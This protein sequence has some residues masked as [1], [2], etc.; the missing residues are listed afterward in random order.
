MDWYFQRWKNHLSGFI[1]RA[2]AWDGGDLGFN[3]SHISLFGCRK[4]AF[5]LVSH[6]KNED[7][8]QFL[9]GALRVLWSKEAALARGKMEAGE[10]CCLDILSPL[11]FNQEAALLALKSICLRDS[12]RSLPKLTFQD[13]RSGQDREMS[14]G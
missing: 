13:S 9:Q 11:P 14:Q 6:L 10:Q 7:D 12:L 1:I 5:P 3:V 2:Y 4:N 8:E